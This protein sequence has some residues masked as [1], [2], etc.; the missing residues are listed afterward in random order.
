MI[1]VQKQ[2][3]ASGLLPVYS[4]QL[5]MAIL[6]TGVTCSKFCE[7]N[8]GMNLFLE[9]DSFPHDKPVRDVILMDKKVMPYIIIVTANKYCMI[10]TCYSSMC[11]NCMIIG[12]I[13]LQDA[14]TEIYHSGPY[15]RH[16]VEE[17]F[18]HMH[19]STEDK[20]QN[21]WKVF[22]LSSSELGNLQFSKDVRVLYQVCCN[23][24]SLKTLKSSIQLL[25]YI[26]I[27]KETRDTKIY[28]TQD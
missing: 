23:T 17:H 19:N 5:V 2:W 25:H 28:G 21:N 12:C 14:R 20:L 10:F 6:N 22:V 24:A 1:H 11:G 7:D 4:K 9:L 8:G 27:E 16:V 15:A 18:N 3:K 13:L 26:I